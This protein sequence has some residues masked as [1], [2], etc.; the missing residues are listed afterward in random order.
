MDLLASYRFWSVVDF[1]VV[2][3]LGTYPV[4]MELLCSYEHFKSGAF[5]SHLSVNRHFLVYGRTSPVKAGT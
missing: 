4:L 5:I 3:D 1:C 2:S